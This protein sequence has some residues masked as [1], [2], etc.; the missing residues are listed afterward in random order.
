MPIF[1]LVASLPRKEVITADGK[2]WAQVDLFSGLSWEDI[3]AVCS[4]ETGVCSG[5]L[6]DYDVTGWTWASVDEVN[7]LFN[8]YIGSAVLGPGPD[9]LAGQWDSTW[10]PTIFEDGWRPTIPSDAIP[11]IA[12]ATRSLIPSSKAE[13][14][15]GAWLDHIEEP[16]FECGGGD[17]AGTNRI[18]EIK[19]A[20]DR[21][22]AWLY[23]KP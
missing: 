23:R 3:N 9:L 6:N 10:A 2:V 1:S 22:G 16:C 21:S 20:S 14:Y 8:F 5:V 11:Q 15:E 7:A 4:A 19:S 17:A 18:T 13:A 12:G